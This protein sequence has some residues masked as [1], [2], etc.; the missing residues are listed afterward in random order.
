MKIR[1]VCRPVRKTPW[2]KRDDGIVFID[3]EKCIGCMACTTACPWDIPVKNPETG[4]AVKCDLCMERLDAGHKPACVAKCATK[5][6]KL[7]VMEPA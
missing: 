1:S 4:T 7:V 2:S 3:Q 5:A 6:L